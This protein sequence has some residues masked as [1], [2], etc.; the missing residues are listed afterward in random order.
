MRQILFVLMAISMV[1]G[2]TTTRTY[3]AISA[4]SAGQ[5]KPG[6]TAIIELVD[7]SRENVTIRSYGSTSVEVADGDRTLRSID[8]ADI[9]TIHAKQ[10]DKGKTTGLVVGGVLILGLMALSSAGPIGFPSGAPAL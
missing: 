5:I 6:T 1:T 2:C 9:R 4:A 8:Y 7:G 3:G 10:L